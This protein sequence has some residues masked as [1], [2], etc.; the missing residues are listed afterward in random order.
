MSSLESSR[1]KL[2]ELAS[3]DDLTG[4]FNRRA[5]LYYLDEEIKRSERYGFQVSLLMF[6]LDHFKEI[7][8]EHGHPEGDEVLR[9]I[10]RMAEDV[11][12]ES[13][14]VGRLGGDEFMVIFPH[15]P[16]AGAIKGAER[17]RSA[18]HSYFKLKNAKYEVT[19]TGG[20]VNALECKSAQE[21]IQMVDD[22]MYKAKHLGRNKI[23]SS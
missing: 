21:L 20:V 18:V 16:L 3:K 5:I 11:F 13:D 9:E 2:N 23:I 19:L 10:A 7:N 22:R 1:A 14:I 17:M 6:D 15:T 8:D 4:L 12:R